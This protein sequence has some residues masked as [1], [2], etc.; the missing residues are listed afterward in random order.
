MVLEESLYHP[1]ISLEAQGKGA[2]NRKAKAQVQL[3]KRPRDPDLSTGCTPEHLEKGVEKGVALASAPKEG[4]EEIGVV[5][6]PANSLQFSHAADPNTEHPD[7]RSQATSVSFDGPLAPGS[8]IFSPAA[9]PGNPEPRKKRRRACIC[10]KERKTKCDESNPICGH[11][12][13]SQLP[14]SYPNPEYQRE[15]EYREAERISRKRMREHIKNLEQQVVDQ[16]EQLKEA[17]R[18]SSKLEAQIAALI[19]PTSHNLQ[20][21]PGVSVG[22]PVGP[23]TN[24]GFISQMATPH[25]PLREDCCNRF[26]QLHNQ[27]HPTSFL[28]LPTHT[29]SQ[30]G[31]G[32]QAMTAPSLVESRRPEAKVIVDT[33][34]EDGTMFSDTE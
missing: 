21:Q 31:T 26:I 24:G 1:T 33:S 7:S 20:C 25:N 12:Q 30:A 8:D 3:R 9:L 23:L 16:S 2:W 15:Q 34:G 29:Y 28:P 19:A 17:L 14:C 4:S 27:N 32:I 13:A 6:K 18:R 11:C 22:Y 5:G 10:C